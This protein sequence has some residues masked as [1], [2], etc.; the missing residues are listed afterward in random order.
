LQYAVK[1]VVDLL[2]YAITVS[3]FGDLTKLRK[4]TLSFVMSVCPS[5]RMEKLGSHWMDFREIS[6]FVIVWKSHFFKIWQ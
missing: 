2:S 1:L 4:A 5:A 3:F 6:Y